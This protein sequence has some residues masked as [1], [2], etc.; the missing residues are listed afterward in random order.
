MNGERGA[1][2]RSESSLWRGR[3]EYRHHAIAD[4]LSIVPPWFTTILSMT[5]Q[6]RS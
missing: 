1:H 2:R 4:V 3:A 5:L 6:N